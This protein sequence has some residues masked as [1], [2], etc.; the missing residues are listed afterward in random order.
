MTA[1]RRR[2]AGTGGG[3]DGGGDGRRRNGLTRLIERLRSVLEEDFTGR[4]VLHCRDGRVEDYEVT[5][6]GQP[7]QGEGVDLWE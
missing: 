6:R 5:L 4:I 7:R 1:A 3:G 2:P